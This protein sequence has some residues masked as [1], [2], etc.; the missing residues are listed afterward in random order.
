MFTSVQP[1]PITAVPMLCVIT[2]LGPIIAPGSPIVLVG[3]IVSLGGDAGG[4]IAVGSCTGGGRLVVLLVSSDDGQW[5]LLCMIAVLGKDLHL[6]RP[7]LLSVF[8]CLYHAFRGPVCLWIVWGACEVFYNI[9]FC[10]I[11]EFLSTV[12]WSV[13]GY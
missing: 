6:R 12:L 9:G 8:R 11:F 2:P 1:T 4:V 7:F 10:E 13:V 5:V 3:S